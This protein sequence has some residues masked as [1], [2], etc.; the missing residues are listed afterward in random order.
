M[1]DLTHG[2]A[3]A[4]ERA[5]QSVSARFTRLMN[6]STSRWGV[7]T[8]P[9]LV[10][11]A[12][13]VFLL[14]FL[15]ALG[16]DAGPA[17]ARA[18][19][20][21]VFAPISVALAVSVALRGARRAVVAWLARQP[22]PVENLNAVLN[23]LGEALEVTFVGAAPEAA[24]LNVELDKVHPDAFVTGGVEDARTLDIRIGV[25]DSKRNPAATNHERYA[26]VRELVER[27]LVP[28]AERYPIQ[29]VRVK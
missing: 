1:P 13:G 27:V 17:V 26:R 23:G 3:A 5:D 14:V 29:V 15:G 19:G 9:P 2:S 4:G 20:V 25:V 28:L 16:R 22:F 12:S 10:A 8:D 7:L 18:L 11:L 24:E 6:A 21:L